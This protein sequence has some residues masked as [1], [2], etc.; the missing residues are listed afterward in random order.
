VA[1]L[2]IIEAAHESGRLGVAVTLDPPAGHVS[3]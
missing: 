1:N 2:R 3:R